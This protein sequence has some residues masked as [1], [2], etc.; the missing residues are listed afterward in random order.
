MKK[1]ALFGGL[2]ALVMIALAAYYA[3]RPSAG[4]TPPDVSLMNLTRLPVQFSHVA[5]REVACDTC[6]HP[7]E[8]EG[9]YLKCSSRG[10]HDIPGSNARRE[11]RS[12]Y[13]IAHEP[14]TGPY[15]SCLK[16]HLEVAARKPELA[17]GLTACAGSRCHPQ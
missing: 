3:A 14:Q 17:Q 6:H 11:T 2:A 15:Y 8:G 9:N 12:Y 7:V 1:I 4:D 5:M 16:C 10:C 13:R